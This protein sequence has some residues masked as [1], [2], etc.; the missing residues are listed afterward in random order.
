MRNMRLAR[1][2]GSFGLVAALGTTMLSLSATGLAQESTPAGDSTPVVAGCET[3]ASGLY[4]PRGITVA[5]DG[6]VYIAEAGDGG[7]TADYATP[8]AGTPEASDPAT[9]HGDTGRITAV[10]PDGKQSVFVDGLTS[11]VFGT[12]VVG[13]SG[14]AIDGDTMYVSIGGPGPQTAD[15]PPA[16]DADSVI[17]IDMATGETTNIARIGD[18]EREN[19][20]DPNAVDSNLGG[21]AVGTDGLVYVADSGGNTIYT[22]DPATGD[23]SVLAVLDGLPTPDGAPNP[24]RHNDATVDPVPTGLVADPN[25]GVYVSLL[26]GAILW[27]VPGSAQILHVAADGTVTEAAS[28]LNLAVGVAV[29]PA[30]TIYATELSTNFFATPPAAGTVVR[31]AD[32]GTVERVLPDL[33]LPYGIAFGPDGSLYVEIMASAEPGADPTGAVLKCAPASL[34]AS[35]A[36]ATEASTPSAAVNAQTAADSVEVSMVDLAFEPSD[37]TIPADT[38]VSIV[39]TNNGAAPHNFYLEDLDVHSDTLSPGDT[40]TVTVNLPAGTYTYYCN[41]P[42][43]RQAGMEGTLVVK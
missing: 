14:V 23:L 35:N 36:T 43:H 11:Y 1:S 17:A 31:I 12:E 20:P 41:V 34:D 3:I 9:T 24:T 32:D 21:I 5:K 15:F 30:G 38:D 8:Q 4:N 39:L 27:G 19:N 25:G 13:A 22:V 26:T 33:P 18:Y 37:L 16:D 29:D 7:D 42:G 40:A 6:T 28:G 10:T 2:V